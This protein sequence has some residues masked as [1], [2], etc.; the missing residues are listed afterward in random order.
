LHTLLEKLL[1]DISYH[2]PDLP[3]KAISIDAAYVNANLN[4]LAE[5]EDLSRYIL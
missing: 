2:A 5:D 4:E 1:E 3:N